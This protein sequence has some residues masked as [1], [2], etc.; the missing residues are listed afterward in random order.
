MNEALY[1]KKLCENLLEDIQM[2]IMITSSFVFGT[3]NFLTF[4]CTQLQKISP[5]EKF[6]KTVDSSWQQVEIDAVKSQS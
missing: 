4:F 6:L 1:Q 3:K 5:C 2:H